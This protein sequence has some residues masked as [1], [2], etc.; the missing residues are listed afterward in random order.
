MSEIR[1]DG[2][3]AIVTGSGQG[4]G[5]QRRQTQPQAP[6]SELNPEQQRGRRQTSDPDQLCPALARAGIQ[7]PD[8]ENSPRKAFS[9]S[10]LLKQEDMKTEAAEERMCRA[11]CLPSCLCDE[12]KRS[13]CFYVA[14]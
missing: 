2:R 1:F 7:T 3:V 6:P 5:R 4:L 8:S 10:G 11:V 9:I 14:L 13:F 12:A